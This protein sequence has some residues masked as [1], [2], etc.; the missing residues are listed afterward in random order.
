MSDV[1]RTPAPDEPLPG[2]R[3]LERL[4]VGGFGEVWK[5]EAPGGLLK[6]IKI[7]YPHPSDFSGD[8][9]NSQQELKGLERVKSIRH[10]YILYLDRYDIV[11]DRLLIVME[12]ADGTLWD[13]FQACK[14]AGLPGI[15]RAEL[16]ERLAEAA[17]ALDVMYRRYQLQHLDIK[18]QNLFLLSNHTK[19]GDF[20]L[21]KNLEGMRARLTGG[22]SACYSA[23]EMFE[24]DVSSTCDQ[25]SLAIVYQELLT[26]QRPYA[27][28]NPRQLMLQHLT[29]LPELAPLPPD[30]RAIIARALAKQPQDRHASC[31]D[32]INALQAANREAQRKTLTDAA[33]NQ[34]TQ[35]THPRHTGTSKAA[36]TNPDGQLTPAVVLGLGGVGGQALQALR[37]T[38]AATCGTDT[39][40]PHIRLIQMD[41]DAA[42]L[43]ATGGPDKEILCTPLAKLS[44]YQKHS[45]GRVPVH[46]WLPLT[47]LRHLKHEQPTAAGQRWLGRLAFVDH[48][49]AIVRRLR[50]ELQA[51][52]NPIALMTTTR[53]TGL[54]FRTDRPRVYVVAG[55]AGGTGSGM[56]LDAA[57]V[58]RQLLRELGPEP[59]QVIGMLLLPTTHAD[60]P[61]L[62]LANTC[63]AL[64]ELQHFA[65]PRTLF[66]AWYNAS[67]EGLT[68]PAAPFHRCVLLPLERPGAATTELSGIAQAGQL[69]YLDLASPLGAAAERAR[70]AL[71][72]P[73]P[74][75]GFVFHSAGAYRFRVPRRAI[76]QRV[77]RV[78]CARLWQGA[79]A[80]LQVAVQARS[81]EHW[82]RAGLAPESLA[83]RLHAACERTLGGVPAA[84]FCNIAE[85][86]LSEG[87]QGLVRQ[88]AEALQALTHL[89]RW[90]GQPG[91]RQPAREVGMLEEVLEEATPALQ[92]EVQ[93][94]LRDLQFAALG[95]LLFRPTGAE[96][97]FVQELAAVCDK[98]LRQQETLSQE[99]VRRESQLRERIMHAV[100]QLQK[101][102]WRTWH[103]SRTAEELLEAIH[104]YP[105]ARYKSLVVQRVLV[106]YQDLLK[107][108][109]KLPIDFGCCRARLAQF[110]RQFHEMQDP[111]AQ[112]FMQGRLLLPA[113]CRNMQ[114]AAAELLTRLP[115]EPS[116]RIQQRAYEQVGQLLQLRGHLCTLAVDLIRK[117]LGQVYQQYQAF[118]EQHLDW[119][120][121]AGFYLHQA[122]GA[123]AVQAELAAAFAA[124]LPPWMTA[125]ESI[126]S[127]ICLLA[128]PAGDAGQRLGELARPV[129][130]GAGICQTADADEI[131]VYREE[132]CVR[133]AELPQLGLEAWLDYAQMQSRVDRTCHSRMDVLDWLPAAGRKSAVVPTQRH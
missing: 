74:A 87:P 27:G 2:Y 36:A 35:V 84:V 28:A 12:L 78:L 81:A 76:L 15:P 103:R 118:A 40:L 111:A 13:R 29:A 8:Q 62:A 99:S 68:D 20:G 108:L 45:S 97:A 65:D 91:S 19:I 59:P 77:T 95:E 101:S 94:K 14:S 64:R 125:Q 39:V 93:Q 50:A 9:H 89:E 129:M 70:A 80:S 83:A 131:V 98:A 67:E 52:A 42:A 86:L 88:P 54:Q 117:S 107:T 21:V 92:K 58:A 115:A 122:G 130:P 60:T 120:D 7:V 22:L 5:A 82:Q 100:K 114:Q 124:A 24:G 56:F 102:A 49:L 44:H 116:A 30:D 72:P 3:L 6:A 34:T 57:Y 41:I 37:Q 66:T 55:L 47:I 46:S 73:D 11:D 4:G 119:A 133:L 32:M 53:R 63:A 71:P 121:A 106:L 1:P 96:K 18:P 31:T 16:V 33:S 123:Q 48:Y 104:H 17:E 132:T 43:R 85:R 75:A 105:E 61:P 26:G 127:E 109:R 25:Y 128:V 110:Q 113:G 79:R 126:T 69:L 90:V 23:P 112:D 10:P 38:L 51:C